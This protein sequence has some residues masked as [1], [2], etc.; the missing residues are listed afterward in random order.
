MGLFGKLFDKKQCSICGNDIGLLGNRKLADGNLC[1]ECAKKLSP[2]FDDRRNSTVEQIEDHLAYRERNKQ[3]LLQFRP[4]VVLGNNGKIHIEMENGIPKRFVL[5]SSDDYRSA[6]ADIVLFSNV[7]NCTPD[8][9]ESRVEEK[10]RNADG[11]NVSYDPPR[12]EYKYDFYIKL[13]IANCPYFDDMSF[14]LNPRTL[15]LKTV[16]ERNVFASFTSSRRGSFDPMLYAE[17]R[18][19]KALSDQIC[20]YI[21]AGQRGVV[22]S[23]IVGQN[24]D[25]GNV[26]SQLAAGLTGTNLM[27]EN[28][29]INATTTP[30]NTWTCH[31]GQ[32]NTGK[33]CSGC[34]SAK[35][36]STPNSQNGWKCLCGTVNNGRFCSNC[37]SK[38]ISVDDI[39]CSEC[40]W[41]AEPGLSVVPAFCPNCGKRFDENDIR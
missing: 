6:N 7:A 38:Q 31:C 5:S 24:V 10:Y 30:S 15:E 39:E 33:F 8:I 13:T 35:P 25:L 9:R 28:N 16:E 29:Q 21:S 32:E 4:S 17:Y 22:A 2:Y 27:K 18:E 41:T 19:Y 14:R 34:G 12:Y 23:S 11:E 20:Q 26:L 37:G 40:S 3:D 1:K 36:V